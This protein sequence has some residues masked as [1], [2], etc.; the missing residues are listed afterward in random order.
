MAR[1]TPADV[2]PGNPVLSGFSVAY[3]QASGFIAKDVF[4]IVPVDK[5][6]GS[7]YKWGS[8]TFLKREDTQRATGGK[9]NR[10]N[11]SLEKVNFATQERGHEAPMDDDVKANADSQLSLDRQFSE[12]ATAKVLL[13]IENDAQ[14][15][16]QASGSYASGHTTTLSGTSQW[17]NLTQSNPIGDVVTGMETIR[18]KT[19]RYP[20]T[21]VISAAVR[22]KLVQHSQIIARLVNVQRTGT[23]DI[24]DDLLASVLGIKRILV[25]NPIEITSAEGATAT[26]ADLYSDSAALVI[27]DEPRTGSRNFGV[28]WSRWGAGLVIT[29]NYREDNTRSTI[30]R[31]RAK[32]D[33]DVISS[34]SGYLIIDTLA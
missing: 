3:M 21:L 7:F 17:S 5:D 28:T 26:Y 31:S 15:L 33:Q 19:G 12:Y 32:Y 6:E 24:S 25:A 23:G 9:Y 11:P 4:S 8:A 18:G 10:S 34:V 1:V 14:G 16:L 20:D 22:A 27:T 13:D 2:Q 29:E 30:Y